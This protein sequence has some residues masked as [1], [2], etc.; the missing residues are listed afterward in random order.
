MSL[1][2]DYL[3]PDFYRFNEDS[4]NLA[5]FMTSH[6]SYKSGRVLEVGPGCGIITCELIAHSHLNFKDILFVE[7]EVGFKESLESNMSRLK[8]PNNL[9]VQYF[10]EDFLSFRADGFSLI[11]FNPPY[12]FTTESR[13]SPDIRKEGCRRM[14]REDFISW[15]KHVHSLLNTGGEFFFC[16]RLNDWTAKAFGFT[17]VEVE[18]RAGAT[19]Y[20]WKKN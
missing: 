16:H 4:V 9:N 5:K 8:T 2:D 19:F 11:Y 17:E 7:R 20:D 14:A 15:L 18:E 6:S 1:K 12:F 10:Y 3:Q 13:P